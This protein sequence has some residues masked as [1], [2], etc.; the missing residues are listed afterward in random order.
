VEEDLV[1]WDAE[2]GVGVEDLDTAV[3]DVDGEA[4]D[5]M[6][7]TTITMDLAAHHMSFQNI[8]VMRTMIAIFALI[9]IMA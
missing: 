1:V 4:E 8:F 6:E 5:I 9:V 3:M 2:E 7:T